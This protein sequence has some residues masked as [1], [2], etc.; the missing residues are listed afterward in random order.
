MV[1]MPPERWQ[2]LLNTCVNELQSYKKHK[3]QMRERILELENLSGA[4]KRPD[5]TREDKKPLSAESSEQC[6]EGAD[7]IAQLEEELLLAYASITKL[8]SKREEIAT[9]YLLV[10]IRFQ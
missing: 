6:K 9:K 4:E 5:I 7:R 1:E 3:A 10:M 8:E 2:A